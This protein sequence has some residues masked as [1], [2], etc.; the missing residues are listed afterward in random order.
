MLRECFA[1]IT[2]F[3]PFVFCK[4]T[5]EFILKKILKNTVVALPKMSFT[6]KP[7]HSMLG[8]S[9]TLSEFHSLCLAYRIA[10]TPP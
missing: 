8:F 6:Q 2:I 7:Q 5:I 3:K 10:G 4:N 1:Y 9:I